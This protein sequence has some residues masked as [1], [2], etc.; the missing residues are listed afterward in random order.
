MD[1]HSNSVSF[2][3]EAKTWDIGI[4]EVQ[5]SYDVVALYPSVPIKKA[6]AAMMDIINADFDDISLQ[7]KLNI[8]DIQSLIT[9]CLSKCYFL[10]DD[11]MYSVDDAGPIGL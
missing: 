10:W 8:D 9:L 11:K 1:Q 5:V 3:N 6:I 4:N 2:V 7:T